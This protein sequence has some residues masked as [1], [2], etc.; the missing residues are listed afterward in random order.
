MFYSNMN[1]R[2]TRVQLS[3]KTILAMIINSVIP[4]FDS[5]I[6]RFLVCFVSLFAVTS[7]RGQVAIMYSQYMNNMLNINP[8]YT[9]NRA[10]DNVTALYRKQWVNIE[11]APTSFSLSWDRGTDDVGDGLH[12]QAKPVSFGVQLYS[13]RLG[14]E[15]SQGFQSF[16]SY[17]IKLQRSYI[18]F[19]LSAGVMNYQGLYSKVGTYQG[20]DPRF[21]TDIK[22]FF[23]TAGVGVL[24][25]NMNWYVGLSAPA[26]LKTKIEN[27][28]N[29]ITA[30]DGRY[31]LTAGYIF[32]ASDYMKI[33]P[34]IL[35][36][37]V[38]GESLSYNLNVNAWF[39]GTVGAGISYRPKDALVGMVQVQ[40]AP[41]VSIGYAYD[42]LISSLGMLSAGSHELM[43]RYEFNRPRSQYVVSPRYY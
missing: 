29:K 33:K 20:S 24:Y 11:G 14:V 6:I 38:Q 13:D 10:G 9:G 26:L 3:S 30:A 36:R 8:A 12:Q 40:V 23:P 32:T 2:R 43:I 5:V 1:K 28:V 16:Y 34:S 15:I 7:A 25:A 35:L 21:Q 27:D 18:A 19:G 4:G 39:L 31:F 42:Y 41:Q 22:G 17:R 37:Q